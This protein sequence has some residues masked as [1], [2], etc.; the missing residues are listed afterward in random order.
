[1][2]RIDIPDAPSSAWWPL[3]RNCTSASWKRLTETWHHHIR[4]GSR[5]VRKA[6]VVFADPDGTLLEHGRDPCLSACD[7]LTLLADHDVPIVLCSSRTR[8]ELALI[9]QKLHLRHPFV[10]ENGG[11]VF[12]PRGSLAAQ[13]PGYEV[14]AFGGPHQ[15]VVAT[16]QRTVAALQIKVRTFSDMSVGEVAD[17]CGVS[18]AE[19][20]LAQLRD[21]DEPFRILDPDPAVSSRLL[22]ALRRAGLRCFTGELF[23]HV[24]SGTDIRRAVRL[25]K[26]VYREQSGSVLTIGISD[27][28]GDY[29]LLHEVDIPIVVLNHAVNTARLLSKV[30]MARVTSNAGSRGWEEAIFSAVLPALRK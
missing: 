13:L 30:P 15:H 4:S 24:T 22:T 7:A 17:A 23:H 12:L 21:Y 18:L 11:A 20:R 29:S 1:M 16:L 10:S 25:L 26:T 14:L 2:A 3:S 27:G 8:A 9:Q 19:A 6:I 5:D 28:R